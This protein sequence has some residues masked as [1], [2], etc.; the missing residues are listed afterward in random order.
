MIERFSLFLL[1]VFT[2]SFSQT[3]VNI[4]GIVQDNYSNKPIKGASVKLCGR[5]LT[6]ATDTNGMFTVSST[7]VN[8]FPMA[9][10]IPR[11]QF[12]GTQGFVL[13]NEAD[14]NIRICLYDLSGRQLAKI[15]TGK[16]QSGI[17]RISPPD[18][19]NGIYVYNIIT[20]QEKYSI[21]IVSSDNRISQNSGSVKKVGAVAGETA[22]KSM[23]GKSVSTRVADS[24]Q[25][26]KNGYF[27]V[28]I[29]LDTLVKNGLII[30]MADTAV[31]RDATIVPDAS[32]TCFMPDGIPPPERGEAA[33]SI[34]L[35]YSAIH[36]VGETK[37]GHRRQF[38]ISGGTLT[39]SKITAS[40]LTGGLDYELTLATGS[41]E[42]EQINILKVGTT[43]ILM[44]NAGVAPA[45][46]KS[47][48]V[49][50]DFEA[51]NSSSYTWLNTG[52][53]AATRIV[54]AAAKTI[55]LDVYDISKVAL[56][57]TRIQIKD[58]AGVPNQTW[59]CLKW[60]GANDATV[61]TENVTL[62]A[63]ISIGASKR[64][65]RNIIPIT[66]GTTSGRVVGKILSGGADYQL[67][68]L[69]ARYTLAPDNGE[70]IIVR[71]CGS[72]A[73]IPVFE[74]NVKGTYAFLNDNKYMS[75]GPIS[76][77]GGV[78]I[79]FFERK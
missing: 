44:R 76:A 1:I 17:W 41:I 32:W 12:L 24:L 51:P 36:D 38:D 21:K 29:P 40:I 61:F 10:R 69:D 11:V 3:S 72:G 71:N 50:L 43:P 52:K 47:V 68:G 6:N 70:F 30:L 5:N 55:K 9:Q 67:S 48:R 77:G 65:S 63:S 57:A 25:I 26:T 23:R 53:F 42:L 19:Q 39:G 46:A 15:F 75:S 8:K 16:L 2:V 33:F 28:I 34:T 59:D 35:Q 4:S 73:L 74:A 22:S 66:G 27:P 58:P 20:S 54:D 56:T 13:N 62:G 14:Q 64:G 49:V 79:T 31:A 18:L 7:F 45:G 60:S 78:S 37:F